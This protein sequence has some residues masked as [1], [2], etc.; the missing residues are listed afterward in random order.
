MEDYVTT[1]VIPTDTT[2]HT[3]FEPGVATDK[4]P[5]ESQEN[6]LVHEVTHIIDA[7]ALGS[8]SFDLQYLLAPARRAGIET[9]ARQSD[10]EYA[11]CRFGFRAN[12]EGLARQLEFYA[13]AKE[14]P[15]VKASLDSVL[16]T[17][18]AGGIATPSVK[19]Q[20]L[21]L[22]EHAP[23]LIAYDPLK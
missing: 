23:E 14:V 6:V 13:C 18:D 2:I 11:R 20:I 19:Q 7:K 16:M 3:P 8:L 21:I 22:R 12:T 5:L 17:V 9:H 10:V 4:W 1:I 15:F